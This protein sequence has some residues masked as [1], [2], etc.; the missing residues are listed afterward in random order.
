MIVF[1]Q[2]T[3]AGV[4]SGPFDLYSNLD[5]YS[6]PFE[7]NVSRD[8]LIA[9]YSTTVPDNAVTVRITSKENCISS[10][11]ITL[12]DVECDLAGYTEEITTTSTTTTICIRPAGLTTG[13][14]ISSIKPN[15]NV[16]TWNFKNTSVIDAC[17]AFKYFRD[18][19]V[20][21]VGGGVIG[22]KEIQYSQLQ[23]EEILY[24][25]IQSHTNCISV[26]DGYYWFQPNNSNQ[27]T[28]FENT[29]PI[30]IVTVLNGLVSAIDSCTYV[31]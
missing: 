1:L 29:N 25:N 14:C 13:N 3:T 28:Y 22:Y 16:T 27:F 12:R 30:N 15:E 10:V 2:L 7:E 23:I 20:P 8:S 5:A 26:D 31:P 9:G 11:Y 6:E 24:D 4:D 18:N 17:N 21:E 19:Y